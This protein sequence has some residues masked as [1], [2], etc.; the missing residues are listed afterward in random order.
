MTSSVPFSRLLS[1]S[2]V[3]R[4]W[5][6]KRIGHHRMPAFSEASQRIRCAMDRFWMQRFPVMQ[7]SIEHAMQARDIRWRNWRAQREANPP[8]RICIDGFFGDLPF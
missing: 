6:T 5:N 4:T 8:P 3:A 7:S 1:T 2:R